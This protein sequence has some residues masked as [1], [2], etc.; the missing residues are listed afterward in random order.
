MDC[1]PDEFCGKGNQNPSNGATNFDNILFSFMQ[2]FQVVTLEGWTSILISCQQSVGT[3]TCVYFYP[4]VIIGAF[5][6]LNLVTAVIKAK[7]T[8]E[9]DK[10]QAGLGEKSKKKRLDDAPETSEDEIEKIEK[11]QEKI[12][13]I[14]ESKNMSPRTKENRINKLK[15]EHLLWKTDIAFDKREVEHKVVEKTLEED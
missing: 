9:M 7:F 12:D 5:F 15:I 13:K 8:E 14:K 6:I 11:L 2:V 3:W 1:A 4:I 10:R